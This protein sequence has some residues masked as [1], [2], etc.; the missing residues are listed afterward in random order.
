MLFEIHKEGKISFKRLSDA[1]LKR[2]DTHQTHIGLS[3]DSLTF[4]QEDKKEYTSM[5]IYNGYCDILSCEIA[6]IHRASGRKD[7][8]KISMGKK[9]D[10]IVKKIREFAALKP[11][12]V[13]YL[14]WFGLDSQTPVF[15]LV[16]EGTYDYKVLDNYCGLET[17]NNRK[18]I[19]LER[20]SINF[21]LVLDFIKSKLANVTEELTK[22]LEISAEVENNDPKFKQVDVNKAKS[23]I[24]QI[25]REGE[26]L[27]NEYLTRK[28]NERI[29][30]YF[31][32]ING[33][34]EQGKPYDFYVKYNSGQEQWIDAKTTEHEFDQSIIVSKSEI[35]F[36]TERNNKDY[37]IFR[38]FNKKETKAKLKICSECLEYMKIISLNIESLT[39]TMGY[40]KAGLVNYKITIQ[41]CPTS[42]KYISEEKLLSKSML[43]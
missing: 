7:A 15:L 26:E 25:G 18:I 24:Q 43:L 38:V 34:G 5:L 19:I 23:Y 29:V 13:F 32:W 42:F 2:S 33:S 22:E 17:L 35:K 30:D 31:E 28:K 16:E 27:V 11:E 1:D 6:K 40:L 12:K 3:N 21:T 37:A 39:Q 9:E 20:D 4:M 10:N 8:P 14:F 36:I 41:P